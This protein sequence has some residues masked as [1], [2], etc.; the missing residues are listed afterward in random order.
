MTSFVPVIS[1]VVEIIIES[2]DTCVLYDTVNISVN[3]FYYYYSILN[4]FTLRSKYP[5]K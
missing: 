3:L 1:Y 2:D 5:E 4:K